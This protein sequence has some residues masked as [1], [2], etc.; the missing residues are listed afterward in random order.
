M[1][2]CSHFEAYD[3]HRLRIDEDFAAMPL[4]PGA[5]FIVDYGVFEGVVDDESVVVVKLLVGDQAVVVAALELERDDVESIAEG[6][7]E[8]GWS[9]EALVLRGLLVHGFDLA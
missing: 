4:R 3:L 1:V 8:D 6:S 2:G 5:G 7:G 9:A